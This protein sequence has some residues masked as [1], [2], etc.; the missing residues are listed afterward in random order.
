ML[1]GLRPSRR[2]TKVGSVP[3]GSWTNE[4]RLEVDGVRFLVGSVPLGAT[5]DEF[6]VVKTPKL[7]ERYLSMLEVER[8]LRIVELGI[9]EGG[10]TALIALA[11]QPDNLLAADLEP[12]I[13]PLLAQFIRSRNLDT[14]LVPKFGLDQSDRSALISFV[15]QEL[16]AHD[17]D[18]VVDDASHLLAPT[19]ASF[20]VL[21]PRL[22][23]G[24]LFVIED[25]SSECVTAEH[26]ARVVPDAPD[27]PERLAAVTQILHILNSPEEQLPA[28]LVASM[29]AVLA[30][31][32]PSALESRTLFQAI[33]EVAAK[34]DLETLRGVSV[35]Q[36]RP[37]A[38][39]AIELTMVAA[40]RPDLVSEVTI[41]A[42]WLTVR[43]GEG[44]LPL[45]SFHLSAVSHDYFGYLR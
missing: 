32:G 37:L 3:I 5:A 22:R 43:R 16:P 12:D 38:D 14:T 39:L 2:R 21:F 30:K 35:G 1:V 24:G 42:D 13:P 25:W 8:P 33:I 31:E 7:V 15:D 9:K 26:L 4:N 34:A 44:D 41:D 19:R 45:D 23:K 40:T 20:E 18:L 27:F 10:S 11:A 28:E 29:S 6:L 17:L 36:S